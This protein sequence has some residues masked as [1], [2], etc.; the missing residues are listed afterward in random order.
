MAAVLVHRKA[1]PVKVRA[2]RLGID[3]DTGATVANAR[4][5]RR[6][7]NK[8]PRQVPWLSLVVYY[9]IKGIGGYAAEPRAAMPLCR[10]FDGRKNQYRSPSSRVAGAG[11]KGRMRPR[12]LPMAWGRAVD[13]QIHSLNW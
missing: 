3:F 1:R 10:L 8:G 13:H 7:A 6:P 11:S 5:G 12:C 9:I 2:A 4:M